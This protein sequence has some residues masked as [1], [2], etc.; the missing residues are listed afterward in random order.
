MQ[1]HPKKCLVEHLGHINDPRVNR[2]KQSALDSGCPVR[3][4]SEPG[5]QHAAENLVTLRRLALNLLKFDQTKKRGVRGK[6]LNASWDHAY[7]LRLIGI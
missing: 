6:Q 2:T 5:P 3:R 4:R 7:L 1:L